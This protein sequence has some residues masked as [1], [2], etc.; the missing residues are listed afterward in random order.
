VNLSQYFTSN[1]IKEFAEKTGITYDKAE[2]IA[3]NVIYRKLYQKARN[4]D[5]KVKAVR[6][7][8]NRKRAALASA[9]TKFAR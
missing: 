4:T 2:S 7:A 8:Q 1:Q 5:P 9:F 6:K 3:K